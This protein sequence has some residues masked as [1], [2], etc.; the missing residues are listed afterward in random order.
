ME[1][2]LTKLPIANAVFSVQPRR[3]LTPVSMKACP[4][5]K[6]QGFGHRFYN[7]EDFKTSNVDY[8]RGLSHVFNAQRGGEKLRTVQH[9]T[10][11]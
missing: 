11:G 7:I 4:Q 6:T 5:F 3:V 9:Q 1:V 10:I 8:S 2:A